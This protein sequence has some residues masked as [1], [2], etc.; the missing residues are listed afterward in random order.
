MILSGEIVLFLQLIMDKIYLWQ[1]RETRVTKEVPC[2]QIWFTEREDDNLTQR[3]AID[4]PVI[5]HTLVIGL[6]GCLAV[7]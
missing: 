4:N 7:T 3:E 1:P 2:S 6:V 5:G